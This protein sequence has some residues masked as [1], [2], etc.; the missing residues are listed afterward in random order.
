LAHWP[1]GVGEGAVATAEV[2]AAGETDDVGRTPEA[3]VPGLTVALEVVVDGRANNN[4]ATTAT[5]ASTTI[6]ASAKPL[7]TPRVGVREITGIS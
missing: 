5:T 3:L 2:G 6:A 4:A 1:R 7:P